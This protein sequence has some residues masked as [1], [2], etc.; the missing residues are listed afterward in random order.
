VQ[1][2]A[3]VAISCALAGCRALAPLA[4]A[5]YVAFDA[6]RY[7]GR[8]RARLGQCEGG[9]WRALNAIWH[10]RFA[11]ETINGAL[12]LGMREAV[13]RRVAV[14]DNA[15]APIGCV[16]AICHTPWARVLASWN[17]TQG[18]VLI[19]AAS[20]WE[21]RAGGRRIGAGVIGLRRITRELRR[22]SRV[23]VVVDCFS[24]GNGIAMHFLGEPI[25]VAPGAVRIAA[26]AGVPLIPTNVRYA[27]GAIRISFGTSVDPRTL[28][29]AEATRRVVTAFESAVRTDPA[30]WDGII[31]HARR[32]AWTGA[33]ATWVRISMHGRRQGGPAPC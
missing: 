11:R 4:A 10:T 5:V 8:V 12:R 1:P 30:V 20:R 14:E 13:F 26:A 28:G 27:R 6:A 24:D 22:G 31:R 2:L 16:L 32:S 18:V 7:G 15:E 25:H 23:A 33:R 9:S 17:A 3:D 29:V 19:K 21:S